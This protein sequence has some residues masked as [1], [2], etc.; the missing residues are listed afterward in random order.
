MNDVPF[1]KRA[2]ATGKLAEVVAAKIE[3]EIIDKGWP[4]GEVLGSESE[5]TKRF[6]V[7]RAV[8][9]EAVRLLESDMIA[10]MKPGPNGGLIVTPPD[11][12]S[13]AHSMALVLTYQRVNIRQLLDMRSLVEG[14]AASLAATNGTDE[15]HAKLR[16]LLDD[17]QACVE[18]DWQSAN[19]FHVMVAEMSGNPACVLMAQ[20]LIMLTEQQTV[21]SKTRRTVASNVHRVHDKVGQA[22]LARDGALARDLM[23]R[24]ISALDPWLGEA[25]H[26]RK[27]AED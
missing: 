11:L 16:A 22:I 17:E 2:R 20:A 8:F 26:R 5:L 7:S 24:H 13:V 27:S 23:S 19:N 3:R 21:P 14:H 12:E 1:H 18:K 25:Y 4:I 10:R 6:E 15:D 9:R